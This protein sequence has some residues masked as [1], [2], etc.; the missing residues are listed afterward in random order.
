MGF[1]DNIRLWH[2]NAPWVADRLKRPQQHTRGGITTL[3]GYVGGLCVSVSSGG[4]V[5]IDG[6]FPKYLSNGINLTPLTPEGLYEAVESLSDTLRADVADFNV[7]RLEFGANMAM[8]QAPEVYTAALLGY[9]R[10]HRSNTYS[11]TYFDQKQKGLKFYDKGAEL[12]KQGYTY[13]GNLLRY[14]MTLSK[15]IKQQM[16]LPNVTAASLCDGSV[17]DMLKEMYLKEYQKITKE[18]MLTITPMHTPKKAELSDLYM[19]RAYQQDPEKFLA[20]LKAYSGKNRVFRSR[21]LKAVRDVLVEASD[22]EVI[23]ELNKAVEAAVNE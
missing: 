13:D 2:N 16:K 21:I 22:T 15:R 11:T 1:Y 9:S 8:E 17:Y 5:R 23:E 7:S 19:A 12:A 3:T 14:E 18:K 6:S 10:A 4:Y 20:E